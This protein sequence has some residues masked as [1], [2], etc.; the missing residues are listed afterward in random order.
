[1]LPAFNDYTRAYAAVD[2]EKGIINIYTE[3]AV[4]GGKVSGYVKPIAK[5]VSFIDLSEDKSPIN[6]IWQ[7][8]VATFATIFKNQP[9]NQLATKVP[10]E[11]DL[12]DPEVAIWPT[13]A[14]ILKNAFIQAFSG[15]IDDTV[16]FEN[17]PQE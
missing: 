8:I 5:N 2:F 14:G 6:L 10:L 9:E 4:K 3:L 12:S 11:G 16:N 15:S 7:S 13:L 1:M 17:A